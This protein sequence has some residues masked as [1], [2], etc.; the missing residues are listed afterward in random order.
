MYLHALLHRFRWLHAPAVL[1]VLLLQRTPVLRVLAGVSPGFGLQSGDL[2]KSAFALAALGA[3]DTVAGATTFNATVVSPTTVTPTSGAPGATFNASGNANAAFSVAFNV[4]GAPATAKSWKVT[5]TFPPGLTVAGG[6]AVTGGFQVNALKVT[7]SG[8]PTAAAVQSLTVTAYDSLGA[9]AGANKASVT[10][11]ITIVGA[12]AP[13]SFTTHPGSQTVIS[14]GNVTFTTAVTGTPAPTLQ[15]FKGTAALAGKTSA[16]LSLTGVTPADAGDYKVVATNSSA[17]AGVSSNVATLTVQTAPA[18][19]SAASALFQALQTGQTFT[20]TATGNPAPTFS[21]TGLP[22]WAV[23]D[24]ATGVISGTPATTQ[25]GA[26]T[27][28]LTA[29][30]GVAP[31]ASQTFSLVVK[32]AL[33]LWQEANFTTAELANPAVSGNAAILA[34]DGLPNLLH[35]ALGY[36][37]REA[38][39]P[40]ALVFSRV[41]AD[42]ALAYVRP[43]TRL[44]V[45]YGVESSTDLVTWSTT[46]VTHQLVSS[47]GGLDTWRGSMPAGAP[48]VFLRLKVSE[49]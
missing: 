48:R 12:N 5:G 30:N 46:G 31:A 44:G 25:A 24:P 27:I 34:P 41:G 14:G 40:S 19:T 45:A 33:R 4:T 39:P 47:S 36:G 8:T 37:P 3:V 11:R 7:I 2:L 35:Y 23:L 1:L 18:I 42:W 15:W 43:G 38:V 28:T 49:Q 13:P 26:S 29:S 21:A 9:P 32:T 16:T 6:T 17:P 22:A 10:C 20:V